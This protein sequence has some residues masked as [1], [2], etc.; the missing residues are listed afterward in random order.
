[1]PKYHI[2]IFFS[3]DD[4][5]YIANIPDLEYCSAFGKTPQAALEEV[6]VAL[7]LW[8]LAANANNMEIPEAIYKPAY[9]KIA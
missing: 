8:L 9:S 1:M 5:G 2:D 6:L 4:E 3:E 7:E